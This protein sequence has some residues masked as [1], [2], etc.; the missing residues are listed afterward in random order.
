LTL[1]QGRSLG[2]DLLLTIR[3]CR[4]PYCFLRFG[5]THTGKKSSVLSLLASGEQGRRASFAA[6]MWRPLSLPRGERGRC[7]PAAACTRRPR[8][9][10]RHRCCLHGTRVPAAVHA[11][12][13]SPSFLAP[14]CSRSRISFAS[15]MQLSRWASF[16]A[17]G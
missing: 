7:I 12:V 13:M 2:V 14:T 3:S 15:P 9:P 4:P 17:R 5:A 16:S 8:A 11:F 1:S 6:C 10:C